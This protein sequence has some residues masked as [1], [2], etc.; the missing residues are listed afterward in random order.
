ME[1]R[2]TGMIMEKYVKIYLNLLKRE[3]V[4]TKTIQCQTYTYIN[5]NL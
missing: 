1:Q 3:S 2:A 4:L 5:V